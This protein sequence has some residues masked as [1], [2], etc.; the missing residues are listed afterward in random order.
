VELVL[1][2][3]FDDGLIDAVATTPVSTFFG[4][5]PVGLTGGGRPPRIL[6][7]IDRERFRAHVACIHRAGRKFYAT[8]NSNDLGLREYRPGFLEE[9]GAEVDRLL[10]DGVDGFVVALPLL[11]EALRRRHPGVPISASTFARVRTVAQAEY[12]GALGARTI[13]LEEANRDFKLMRA[14]VRRGFEVEVLVN[15]TCLRGCP[16][17]AHHLNTSSLAAQTGRTEPRFEY[18]IF[19]CGLE[20]LRDPSRLISSILVRPE[21]LA[22]YEEAGVHRFKISGRNKP[23]AW[24]VRATRAYAARHYEG[25]LLDIL[26][27]VQTKGPCGWLKNGIAAP[28]DPAA[29]SYRGAFEGFADLAIDNSAFPADFLRVLAAKDCDHLSCAEC[30]YCARIAER[31]VRLGGRPPSEY[32]P[33]AGLAAPLDMLGPMGTGPEAGADR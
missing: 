3:N 28:E 19:E 31:T 16:Y 9:F 14:L 4:N 11:M 5:Y 15:Q 2:S 24:L 23:T 33:P 17:R 13:V 1:A 18:P 26:S 22:L 20:M 21:D 27:L 7:A 6:P 32:A 25:N 30:G 29:A 10:E 12:L 8:L